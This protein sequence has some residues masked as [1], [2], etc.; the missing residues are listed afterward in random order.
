[1]VSYGQCESQF[2]ADHHEGLPPALAGGQ[3]HA[4]VGKANWGGARGAQERFVQEF[5]ILSFR[6]VWASEWVL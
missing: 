3:G 5:L 1:M 4:P 2:L 6:D